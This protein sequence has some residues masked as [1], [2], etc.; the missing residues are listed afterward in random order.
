[1]RARGHVKQICCGPLVVYAQAVLA[2]GRRPI[3]GLCALHITGITVH[4]LLLAAD[5]GHAPAATPSTSTRRIAND[6]RRKLLAPEIA[7]GT[8]LGWLTAL[9]IALLIAPPTATHSATKPSSEPEPEPE[10]FGLAEVIKLSRVAGAATGA[11]RIDS[12]HRFARRAPGGRADCRGHVV[13]LPGHW[14]HQFCNCCRRASRGRQKGLLMVMHVVLS[15]YRCAKVTAGLH[16][17]LQPTHEHAQ[18]TSPAR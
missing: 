13:M 11:P 7:P 2:S 4:I 6:Q 8:R 14:L 17:R 10:P 1:M 18:C 15:R 9:M 3:C 12:I 16:G 5:R